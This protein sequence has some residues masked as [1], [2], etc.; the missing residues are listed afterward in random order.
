M[1]YLN[2]KDI[3]IQ[4][5]NNYGHFDEYPFNITPSSVV[6]IDATGDLRC[7]ENSV[8]EEYITGNATASYSLFSISAS[9]VPNLYPQ[10]TQISS[11]WASASL[12]SSLAYNVSGGVATIQSANIGHVSIFDNNYPTAGVGEIIISNGSNNSQL[13]LSYDSGEIQP[14]IYSID[15]SFNLNKLLINANPLLLNPYAPSYGGFVAIAKTSPAYTLD[16]GGDINFDGN[17]YQNSASYI[18]ALANF[19]NTSSLAYNV[20]GGVAIITSA[21]IN[22]NVNNNQ[23]WLTYDNASVNPAIY[24]IDNSYTIQQLSLVGNP[25][26]LNPYAPVNGGF[27]GVGTP[28]PRAT[29]DIYGSL[30]VTASASFL[31]NSFLLNSSDPFYVNSNP[32]I[33][34]ISASNNTLGVQ[35]NLIVGSNG[36]GGNWSR[37]NSDGSSDFGGSQIHFG[38][39]GSGYFNSTVGIGGTNTSTNTLKVYG[40]VSASNYTGSLYGTA[41]NA[42]SSSWS[43]TQVPAIITGSTY[44]ITASVALL[45]I[46]AVTSSYELSSSFALVSLSSSISTTASYS[47]NASLATSA[48]YITSS[49]IRGTVISSSYAITA[50]NALS[51]SYV[52]NLYPTNLSGYVLT[53]SFNSYT[54]SNNSIVNSLVNAT[55]S[56]ITNSQTSSMSVATASFA[57]IANTSSYALSASWSPDNDTGSGSYVSGSNSFISNLSGS[58]VYLSGSSIND[59]I[60]IISNINDYSEL[61]MQNQSR[62]ISASTDLTITNDL[63]NSNSGFVDI[64]INSS[65][66]SAS[67]VGNAN[68]AYMFSITSG[69][70]FIGNASLQGSVNLF[71]GGYTN[72]AS[73]TL[74]SA[75]KVGIG[76]LNPVNT[77]DVV[78]NISASVI[79]AS[80]F[81]GTASVALSASYLINSSPTNLIKSQD[82]TA[83]LVATPNNISSSVSGLTAFTLVTQS[84]ITSQNG[85]AS[86]QLNGRYTGSNVNVGIPNNSYPWGTSSLNGSYFSTWNNNTNV[87]DILRFFAGALSASYP[88]PT[89][90]TKT[91]GSVTATNNLGGSTV[92]INGIVPIS[93]SNATITYLQPLG[94]ASVGSTIFSGFTFKNGTGS[95]SYGSNAAGSTTVSSSL[96]ASAFGLGPLNSG[97]I[98]QVNLSGSFLLTYASSSVGITNF[99]SSVVTL[100]NQST[101]NLAATIATPIALNSIPSANIAVIPAVYQDGYFN[102]FTGSNLTSSALL[103]S[104]SSSGLYGFSG[105]VGLSSGSSAYTYFTPAPTSYY[106]TPIADANFTQTITSPTSS[107]FPN[108]AVSRSLSGV[109]YLTSGSTYHYNVTASGAFNPLYLSGTVSTVTIPVNT[110]TLVTTNSISLT[111]NP[112]IQTA[113]VVKSSSYAVTRAVGA[114]PLESDVIVFDVFMGATGLGTT[115]AAS[116]SSL[117]TFTVSNTTYNRANSGTG[118]GSQTIGVHNAGTFGQPAS[119]GSLLYFGRPDGY[120]TSSLNFNTIAN[121]EQFLDE[122]N[123]INL[124][125]SVLSMSGSTWNSASYIS[126]SDLQIKPGFLVNPSATAAGHTGYWYPTNYGTTFKYYIRHFKTTVV[127]NKLQLVLT[128]LTNLVSWADTSTAN[129]M[130]VA[131]L[132]ESGDSNVYTNCRLYDVFNTATN[133]IQASVTP[134]NQTSAGTNP[135]S[136]NIDL[137]GNNGSGASVAGSTVVFPMRTADGAILDSTQLSKD[138]VYVLIRYNGTPS[139]PLTNIAVSSV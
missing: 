112:T 16:V 13:L 34:L 129:S 120:V 43:P 133:L 69:S 44:P 113:G 138:E 25:L 51:A 114:Y 105:S 80:L 116:A 68:D 6:V 62:G 32:T 97:N 139:A 14:A 96:G 95:M 107:I 136:S 78:G 45:A 126:G 58:K 93:S 108:T 125:N 40:S 121:N 127:V 49:N 3:F 37:L 106:Y 98:T 28:T 110:L 46:N 4:R 5:K 47:F 36:N 131:L 77:L 60:T 15:T 74:T 71:A 63:G 52:P 55:S 20:S 29:L 128:G 7:I 1:P 64:G 48:S 70:L 18:P 123:R 83:I 99:T 82:S 109:P 41:S 35:G 30:N 11:S 12:S 65:T 101:Q 2:P 50:S 33:V 66:Y 86:L 88:T 75:S 79:T 8:F 61:F 94:W 119:S 31:N 90:N 76:T 103:T 122:A 19:A 67:F 59:P 57:A 84:V 38:N 10:Q 85:T 73:L 100:L 39:D 137:Y 9:Y 92:T 102:S 72:T 17:L 42:I 130:A 111:T 115:T 27:V 21:R 117:N 134:T 135:F 24:S 23:L 81:L 118:L 26:L 56:Y 53:S 22:N 124:T 91:F 54:S 104:V 87:S 89:P 132:F